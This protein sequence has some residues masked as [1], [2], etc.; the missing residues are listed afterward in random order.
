[1]L[2]SLQCRLPWRGHCPVVGVHHHICSSLLHPGVDLHPLHNTIQHLNQRP[3]HPLGP[4]SIQAL[5]YLDNDA[6]IALS[7]FSSSPDI[8]LKA[9]FRS[10]PPS[11]GLFSLLFPKDSQLLGQLA[12]HKIQPHLQIMQFLTQNQTNENRPSSQVKSLIIFLLFMCAIQLKLNLKKN[13]LHSVI[14]LNKIFSA[15][16]RPSTVFHGILFQLRRILRLHLMTL[17]LL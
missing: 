12:V 15:L 14:T 5:P 4:H 13:S 1:M 11:S 2:F 17:V 10:Q 8:D 16:K 3:L 7:S 6:L 9:L